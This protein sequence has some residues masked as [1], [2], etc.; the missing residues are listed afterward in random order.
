MSMKGIFGFIKT[1]IVLTCIGIIAAIGFYFFQQYRQNEILKQIIQRL[2][3]DSRS[4]EVIVTDANKARTTIKFVEYDA[5]KK[6][7][8]PR[9]FTFHN[10]I[11]QFQSLVIRFNDDYIKYGDKL[12]GKSAYLF[13]KVFSLG[14]SNSAEI[15]EINKIG[16][17]PSGYRTDI[18]NNNFEQKLW[19]DFWDYSLRE[20]L[21]KSV[22]IKNAQIEA[23]GTKFV[24]G[25]LYTIKIEHAGGLRIDS[26]DL[27]EIVKGEKIP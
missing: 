4:A 9:Y 14:D 25:K 17:V 7:L 1:A 3:A 5:D 6:P 22:G 26:A 24:P 19:H 18:P 13:W 11:I 2:T 15:Y 20:E 10:N 12:R 23:P 8:P 27:P 16:Q 21:A